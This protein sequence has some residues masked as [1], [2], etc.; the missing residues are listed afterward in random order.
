MSEPNENGKQIQID[1]LKEGIDELKDNM[2]SLQEVVTKTCI[3]VETYI[4]GRKST[5]PQMDLILDTRTKVKDG[6]K[7]V[8]ELIQDIRED[9][10]KK[11][12]EKVDIAT[13][14]LLWGVICAEGGIIVALVAILKAAGVF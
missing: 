12:K 8:V 2:K 10:E 11:L 7:E 14:K 5:C 9:I 4:A 3:T 1:H 13:V 6:D